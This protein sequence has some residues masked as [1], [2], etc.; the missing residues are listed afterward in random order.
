MRVCD[1]DAG[2]NNAFKVSN[3]PAIKDW[4]A[5]MRVIDILDQLSTIYGQLSPAVLE[6]NNTMFYNPYLVADAPEVLF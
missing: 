3:N 4:H 5:G 2:M 1:V 6:T